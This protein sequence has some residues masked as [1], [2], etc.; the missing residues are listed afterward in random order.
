MSTL[1]IENIAFDLHSNISLNPRSSK[2]SSFDSSYDPSYLIEHSSDELESPSFG[3]S[4]LPSN[5]SPNISSGSHPLAS[6]FHFYLESVEAIFDSF[7]RK[8]LSEYRLQSKPSLLRLR[9]CLL[10]IL[11]N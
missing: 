4:N 5:A 3:S 10:S 7:L 8:E 1:Q 2:Y 6:S 11:S 9:L